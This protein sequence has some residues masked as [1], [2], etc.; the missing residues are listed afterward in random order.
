VVLVAEVGV[1]KGRLLPAGCTIG[2]EPTA[3]PMHL[4]TEVREAAG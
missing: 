3:P 1:R 2:V 4:V